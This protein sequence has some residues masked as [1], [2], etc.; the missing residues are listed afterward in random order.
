MGLPTKPKTIPGPKLTAQKSHAEFP[1]LKNIQ[2]ALNDLVRKMKNNITLRD[3]GV[4]WVLDP[5]LDISWGG[6]VVS[7]KIFFLPFGPQFGLR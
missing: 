6:G 3:T 7:N 5:D 2:K 1:S 4:L